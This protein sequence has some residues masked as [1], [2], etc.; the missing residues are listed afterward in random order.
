MTSCVCVAMREVDVGA[1]VLVLSP[2]PPFFQ[3]LLLSNRLLIAF[4]ILASSLPALFPAGL[5]SVFLWVRTRPPTHSPP[6][7]SLGQFIFMYCSC[8]VISTV[9]SMSMFALL[10]RGYT[11]VGVGVH[12]IIIVLSWRWWSR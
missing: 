5:P 6:P 11:F 1:G 9:I 7:P 8:E 10:Y 4:R 12:F 3:A 2:L